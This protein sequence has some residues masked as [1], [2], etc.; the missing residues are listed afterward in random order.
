MTTMTGM[1]VVGLVG[2]MVPKVWSGGRMSEGSGSNCN[3]APGQIGRIPVIV[4][5]VYVFY[6]IL[7]DIRYDRG[8]T[9]V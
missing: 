8:M 9:R 2:G 7:R 3:L 4:V 6:C 1:R 5:I